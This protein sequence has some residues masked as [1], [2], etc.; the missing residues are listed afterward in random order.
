ME[1][2][3]QRFFESGRAAS[4]W[5]R[6][7]EQEAAIKYGVASCRPPSIH[8]RELSPLAARPRSRPLDLEAGDENLSR[9]PVT[10]TGE[11]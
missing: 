5:S 9:P 4:G 11:P 7:L 6:S 10:D 1:V 3:D 8:Q 2:I